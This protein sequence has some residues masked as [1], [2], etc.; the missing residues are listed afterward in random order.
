MELVQNKRVGKEE[1]V[2]SGVCSVGGST[3]GMPVLCA[4][5]LTNH[6]GWMRT[7]MRF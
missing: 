5:G 7:S 2:R 6:K 1:E 4:M 3:T